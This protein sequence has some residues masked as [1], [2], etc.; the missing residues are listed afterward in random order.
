MLPTVR[1]VAIS[2]AEEAAQTRS[3][4]AD[5]DA[6]LAALLADPDRSIAELARACGWCSQ[7]S[8]EPYK[9]KVHR[10]LDRLAKEKAPMLVKKNRDQWTLT[11]EGKNAARK[12]A[13][14]QRKD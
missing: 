4:R 13:L 3:T 12:A 11:E 2:E 14:R 9:S 5:E 6:V 10:V 7:E 1:A 8:G